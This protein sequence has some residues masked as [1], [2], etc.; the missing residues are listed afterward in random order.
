MALIG[1]QAMGVVKMGYG[2]RDQGG[3]MLARRVGTAACATDV[4]AAFACTDESAWWDIRLR[5]YDD[6]PG[7]WIARVTRKSDAFAHAM[8]AED[9]EKEK[10]FER[11]A[12]AHSAHV[13]NE[14]VAG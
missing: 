2:K 6:A 8:M 11:A 1:T 3:A 10:L 14:Q 13:A 5:E 7:F 12:E 9:V 4:G